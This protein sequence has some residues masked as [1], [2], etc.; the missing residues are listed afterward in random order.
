MSDILPFTINSFI[1][2]TIAH[3]A[4]VY[5]DELFDSFELTHDSISVIVDA[6]D[7][8]LDPFND[9]TLLTAVNYELLKHTDMLLTPF[10]GGDSPMMQLSWATA[11]EKLMI[12]AEGMT[13]FIWWY[14]LREEFDINKWEQ[15]V[16]SSSGEYWMDGEELL[17]FEQIPLRPIRDVLA[18]R[19]IGIH[20]VKS[21]VV[22]TRI[23]EE[24]PIE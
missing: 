7:L 23:R 20:F 1:K 6:P 8:Y 3:G 16:H 9:M 21:Y 13:N 2:S 22:L 19:G 14:Y 17:R 4:H 10:G 5:I 11:P 18:R 12:E 24:N 15:G